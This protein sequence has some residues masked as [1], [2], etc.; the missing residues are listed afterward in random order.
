[1]QQAASRQPV[2]AEKL[3]ACMQ[4]I[5]CKCHFLVTTIPLDKNPVDVLHMVWTRLRAKFRHR[6]TQRFGGDRSRQ[7][8][9]ILKY[10]VDNY[11]QI[12]LNLHELWITDN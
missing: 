8:K 7:N 10:L 1:M 4:V 12:E 9:Q 3:L 6:T 2:T 11:E 5:F